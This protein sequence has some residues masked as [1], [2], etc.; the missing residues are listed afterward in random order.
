MTI[1]KV[2]IRKYYKFL[3]AAETRHNIDA[4]IVKT[5]FRRFSRVNF[6][7]IILTHP[8]KTISLPILT[9]LDLKLNKI[10]IFSRSD[11][12]CCKWFDS[13]IAVLHWVYMA[14]EKSVLFMLHFF[15]YTS[16]P[17]MQI[18]ILASLSLSLF[19]IFRS[20]LLIVYKCRIVIVL[21]CVV[22]CF[23]IF[24]CIVHNLR[25]YIHSS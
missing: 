10:C 3:L 24:C 16:H 19:L 22:Y 11:R 17:S 23:K 5:P 25:F 4:I 14:L 20:M 1:R 13:K 15:R 21:T 6:Q 18:A 8:Y 9:H 2:S 12:F 7:I